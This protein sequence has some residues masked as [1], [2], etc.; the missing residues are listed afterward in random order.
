M[1]R[2]DKYGRQLMSK[3]V[4]IMNAIDG[5]PRQDTGYIPSVGGRSMI[6][7]NTAIDL[8]T[9]DRCEPTKPRETAN[10]EA[11]T[12]MGVYVPA[13]ADD[14]EAMSIAMFEA[15]GTQEYADTVSAQGEAV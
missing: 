14:F 1:A 15:M 5:V 13:T 2:L 7:N 6:F 10:I 12:T 4:E 11:L 3:K 8:D 9:G